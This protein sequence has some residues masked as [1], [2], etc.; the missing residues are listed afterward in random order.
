MNRVLNLQR[1]A[2]DNAIS[3]LGNSSGSSAH[4]CCGS[5]EQEM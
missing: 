2:L 3:L 1:L 4:S 5:Q